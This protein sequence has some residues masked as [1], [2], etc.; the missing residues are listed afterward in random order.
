MIHG[1]V[2]YLAILFCRVILSRTIQPPRIQSPDE[3]LGISTSTFVS[4]RLLTSYVSSPHAPPIDDTF[5]TSP[6]Y[7][8]DLPSGEG[9][10]TGTAVQSRIS[11]LILH[12]EAESGYIWAH[13][14][15]NNRVNPSVGTKELSYIKN[16]ES[17]VANDD[18]FTI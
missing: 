14:C 7:T 3:Y 4:G 5:I 17:L 10:L 1:G 9:V 12:T 2:C 11:P 6:Q 18:S 16:C 13:T 8:L 15:V